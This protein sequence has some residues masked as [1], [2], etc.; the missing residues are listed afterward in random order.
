MVH[1]D[2]KNIYN[3][4]MYNTIQIKGIH[5]FKKNKRSTLK[6]ITSAYMH[7]YW[8]SSVEYKKL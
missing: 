4:Y 7:L 8:T 5:K 6:Y 2:T 1:M 3:I